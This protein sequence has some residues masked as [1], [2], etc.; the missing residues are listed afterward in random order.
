MIVTKHVVDVVT[1]A[2][3]EADRKGTSRIESM[4]LCDVIA[5]WPNIQQAI[6]PRVD[7]MTIGR[8]YRKES[9]PP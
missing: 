5:Q 4:S 2:N 1:N 7:P 8:E 9:A 3:E 6:G